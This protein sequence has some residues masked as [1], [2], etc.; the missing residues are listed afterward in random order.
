MAFLL[1]VSV[2][3]LEKWL[4]ISHYYIG[5][6]QSLMY[7]GCADAYNRQRTKNLVVLLLTSALLSVS[8][9]LVET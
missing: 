8:I 5:T 2:L 3:I 9:S 4:W 6:M 7:I 1:H